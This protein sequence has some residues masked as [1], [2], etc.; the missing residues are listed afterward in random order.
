[1]HPLCSLQSTCR[2]HITKAGKREQRRET[3]VKETP[4]ANFVLESSEQPGAVV[5]QCWPVKE[6]QLSTY[7]CD[8]QPLTQELAGRIVLM[9]LVNCS[10]TTLLDAQL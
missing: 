9:L 5:G 1:M 6:P 3:G 10:W 2:H 7:H 4:F 8:L